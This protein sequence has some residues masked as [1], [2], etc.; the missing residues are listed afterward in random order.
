MCV[1][2]QWRGITR[3]KPYV[4]VGAGNLTAAK[5]A[6]MSSQKGK[7]ATFKTH[8]RRLKSRRYVAWI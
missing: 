8:V 7:G 2:E 3:A 6:L 1:T 4:A 5:M